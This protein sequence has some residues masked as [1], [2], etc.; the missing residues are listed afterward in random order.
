MKKLL[1]S[2]GKLVYNVEAI[3][4]NTYIS[5]KYKTT[6]LDFSFNPFA[7]KLTKSVKVKS[8]NALISS[9]VFNTADGIYSLHADSLYYS[10]NK[11]K[12]L[13]RNLKFAPIKDGLYKRLQKYNKSVTFSIQ[14]PHF[15]ISNTNLSSALEYDSLGLKTVFLNKPSFELI[16]YPDILQK[17]TKKKLSNSIKRKAINKLVRYSTDAEVKVYAQTQRLDSTSYSFFTQKRNAI[18][19]IASRSARAIIS[20]NISAKDMIVGDTAIDIV[21]QISNFAINSIEQIAH[22]SLSRKDLKNVLGIALS[23]IKF[24]TKAYND[25]EV[26]KEELFHLVG[27]FLPKISTDTLVVKNGKILYR[28]NR[29]KKLKNIVNVNFDLKLY[30]FRFDTLCIDSTKRIL[31]SDRFIVSIRN[32]IFDLADSLYTI[33]IANFT[34]DSKDSS[35]IVRN[36]KISPKSNN[37]LK[38]QMNLSF[39]KII[40]DGIDYREL[41]FFHNFY[42]NNFTFYNLD[43]NVVLPAVSGNKEEKDPISKFFLPNKIKIVELKNI[44]VQDGNLKIVKSLSDLNLS[45]GFEFSLLNFKIDSV[46]SISDNRYFIPIDEFSLELNKLK[47]LSDDSSSAAAVKSLRIASENGIIRFDSVEYSNFISDSTSILSSVKEK[48]RMNLFVNALEVSGLDFA[49]F[50][51]ENIISYEKIIIDTPNVLISN[52]KQVKAE[53]LDVKSINIFEKVKKFTSKITGDEFLLNNLKIG[54]NSY[55]DTSLHKNEFKEISLKLL[56]LLI[57]STTF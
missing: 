1:V 11:A 34:M 33:R 39:P 23:Q 19:T 7:D 54:I 8:V 45:A 31:F 12:L 30:K 49:L 29:E 4:R 6:V 57:D 9:L 55:T 50:R 24:L 37:N 38:T 17:N 52:F 22:D 42:A 40:C 47:Y 51:F 36:L 56:G 27:Q 35:I 14:I 20:L 43:A 48:N 25:P 16:T 28:V 26:D 15:T 53:K 5:A 41:Y 13:F 32:S 46:T 2:E 18:D 10:T 3:N 21:S 44:S